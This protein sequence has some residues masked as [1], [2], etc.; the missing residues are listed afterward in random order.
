MKYRLDSRGRK[1]PINTRTKQQWLD[2]IEHD[3]LSYTGK[4]LSYDLIS[5]E[6]VASTDRIR[7]VCPEHGEFE[8]TAHSHLKH[9]CRGCAR[10]RVSKTKT[11]Q[12]SKIK[13]TLEQAVKRAEAALPHLDFSN[14]G[15]STYTNNKDVWVVRCR[16]ITL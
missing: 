8:V 3:K 5:S 12:P 11:G 2:A 10:H 13:M 16:N 7:Y 4:P 1:Q 6:Y 14:I 15:K 9:G